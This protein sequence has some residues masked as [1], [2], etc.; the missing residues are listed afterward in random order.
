MGANDTIGWYLYYS[1]DG[2]S[3][4][5]R[6]S[7]MVAGAGGFNPSTK[8]AAPPW[9]YHR[10]DMR[11]VSGKWAAGKSGALPISQVT[12]GKFTTAAGSWTTYG[13]TYTITG[14]EG[15]RRP[16]THLR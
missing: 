15:E 14:A 8:G 12:N 7:A 16:A 4:N 5:V 2:T 9:P 10:S 1:D 11:H 13:H 6:M 3:Y